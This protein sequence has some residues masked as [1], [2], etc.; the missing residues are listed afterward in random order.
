MG[1]IV[2]ICHVLEVALDIC[3]VLEVAFDICHVLEVAFDIC[4]V[5]EVVLCPDFAMS[6]FPTMYCTV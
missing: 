2:Y 1:C 3:L 4:H 5:L 6:L